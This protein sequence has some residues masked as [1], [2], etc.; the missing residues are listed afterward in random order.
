MPPRPCRRPSLRLPFPALAGLFVTGIAAFGAGPGAK[1]TPTTTIASLATGGG[2]GDGE[3]LNP[4]VDG[5]G[6]VIAYQSEAPDLVGNDSNRSS[7]VFVRDVPRSLTRLVSVNAGGTKSGNSESRNP[8]VSANGRF[9]AFQSRANDLVAAPVSG[10]GD[11]FVR[12]LST[13]VT[14]LVSVS[15]AGPGGGNGASVA[16]EISADGRFVAFE[17]AATDLVAGFVGVGQGYDVYLRDLR[18]GTTTLVSADA[19]GLPTGGSFDQD[20]YYGKS[21][22]ISANGRYVAFVSVSTALGA[23]E[24]AAQVFVRDVKKRRTTLVSAVD[25][26]TEA[27]DSSA[28]EPTMSANGRW[29]AFTSSATNL[30]PAGGA[31]GNTSQIHLRDLR[32]RRTSIASVQPDGTTRAE[33]GGYAA[34]I[35]ANGKLLVFASDG[36]DLLEPPLPRT[37]TQVFLRDLAKRTNTLVSVNLEGTGGG[38]AYSEYPAVSG[39]G[40][41][42]VFYGPA[43]DLVAGDNNGTT[44]V[45]LRRLR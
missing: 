41:A 40:R 3:S 37:V 12:D 36:G 18:R 38:N 17:S 1:F 6:R 8:S 35:S 20:S 45:F 28:H 5:K 15:F 4:A 24:V 14:T 13:G 44:D 9:V 29:V 7:D 42:V 23:S 25:R 33:Y 39:D 2:L 16:P 32:R 30:V 11:V 26:G 27:G 10:E 22:S 43:S 21:L 19:D 34:S 31:D